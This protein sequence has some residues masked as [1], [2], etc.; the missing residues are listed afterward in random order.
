MSREFSIRRR[1]GLDKPASKTD[2][3]ASEKRDGAKNFLSFFS[4]TPT[5][6]QPVSTDSNERSLSLFEPGKKCAAIRD[7]A[8]LHIYKAR[9]LR[10]VHAGLMKIQPTA[11][12]QREDEKEKEKEEEEE[13]MFAKKRGSRNSSLIS[14]VNIQSSRGGSTCSPSGGR[15]SDAHIL[16]WSTRFAKNLR[17]R[18][19]L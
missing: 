13:A 17:T 8:S 12:R 1:V 9:K 4:S 15:S 7:R 6:H 5:C 3:D 11:A 2:T 18:S 16:G 19:R 14:C 10:I